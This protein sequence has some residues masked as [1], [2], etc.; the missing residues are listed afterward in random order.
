MTRYNVESLLI[1]YFQRKEG[2]DLNEI[3][4]NAYKI[5]TQKLSFD[6][7]QKLLKQFFKENPDSYKLDRD[8]TKG[9][10]KKKK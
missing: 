4:K 5:Q 1:S 9:Y 6:E 10:L 7:Q 3:L 8:Y 2:D